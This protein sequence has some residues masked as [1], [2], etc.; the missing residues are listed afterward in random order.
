[1]PTSLN[2]PGFGTD[3]GFTPGRRAE[4]LA[5]REARALER[6]RRIAHWTDNAFR[7][8]GTRWRFGLQPIIGL[9]PV[10]GDLLGLA[11][12]CY[13]LQQAWTLGVPRALLWRMVGNALADFGIGLLPGV[14]D[15]GDAV[16][17]ANA[18]N[19]RL[20]ERHLAARQP[21]PPRAA[22]RGRLIAIGL[23]L[24]GVGL[25]LALL[26]LLLGGR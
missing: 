2:Q 7:I 15:V 21:A 22:W 12:T 6:V 16:F 1:M 3:P 19:L 17:K 18:R 9:V 11:I 20:L 8:P 25:M 23:W 24:C 26:Y 13:A 14:G 4:V 5:A 10:L